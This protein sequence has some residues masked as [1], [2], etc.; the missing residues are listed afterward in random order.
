M[1][2]NRI[3][4]KI[5]DPITG[6]WIPIEVLGDGGR[7]A[8]YQWLE[9]HPEAT[10]SVLDG[11]ISTI[12]LADGSV[13]D[14]KLA[15]NSVTSS[16]IENGSVTN[17]K[18]TNSSVTTP[19]ISDNS[20][21][22]SK[23][24]D[25]AVTSTKLA[26]SSV[27]TPSILDSSVVSSKIADNSVTTAKIV[28]G[29][30]TSAKLLD[31]SVT[32]DKL[33]AASVT[34]AKVADSNITTAKIANSAINTAK[35]EDG[36]VT[37]AKIVDGNVTTAKIANNAVTESKLDPNIQLKLLKGYVTP[38]NY[39]AVGDGIADDT[40]AWQSAV[41]S[42]YNVVAGSKS[43]RCGKITITENIEIDCNMAEFTCTSDTLFS[44]KGSIIKSTASTNSYNA[45]ENFN[46]PDSTHTGVAFLRN[47]SRTISSS[48]NV[49]DGMMINS[50]SGTSYDKLP[51]TISNP[52]V[53]EISPITCTLINIGSVNHINNQTNTTVSI[54]YGYKCK[55]NNLI[56]SSS[57]CTIVSLSYCMECE[58]SDILGSFETSEYITTYVTSYA[59]LIINSSRTFVRNC[60]ITFDCGV[61][62]K[63]DGSYLSLN[64]TIEDCTFISIGCDA[65]DDRYNGIGT[66]IT[67]CDLHGCSLGA[68]SKITRC[69]IYQHRSSVELTDP[70][71]EACIKIV[72]NLV[73]GINNL[74]ISNVEFIVSDLST[75][76]GI[77][78]SNCRLG[79]KF[80]L[81]GN[82]FYRIDDL[83][84]K[85]IICN[86]VTSN[87]AILHISPSSAGAIAYWGGTT[88]LEN[89]IGGAYFYTASNFTFTNYYKFIVRNCTEDSTMGYYH[90]STVLTIPSMYIENSFVR[91]RG[92]FNYLRLDNV[93][94]FSNS[95]YMVAVSTSGTTL[96]ASNIDK[97][98]MDQITKFTNARISNMKYDTPY[99]FAYVVVDP[100]FGN[101]YG[102]IEAT[103]IVNYT[104]N[105]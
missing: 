35:L 67:R 76:T 84:I 17:E 21:T 89:V 5:R 103:G 37:T 82:R 23:L 39:G 105:A 79:I 2:L 47:T 8:I 33:G 7:D 94:K 57:K 91:L 27:T 48:I 59:I 93:R 100:T 63:T 54:E 88:I 53:D 19:K 45:Y 15:D 1:I 87:F 77:T 9:E 58:I 10:T 81:T 31:R 28:D 52:T 98:A 62:Y 24:A 51:V 3:R 13:T 11:S 86:K 70:I 66:E 69:K 92:N 68:S 85:N 80:E 95:T 72:P 40:A 64:N 104:Y 34:T 16:K 83:R 12:K 46:L 55:V 42:G 25:G 90:E 78:S 36:S 99:T 96:E 74:E 6:S 26:N 32:E 75:V 18:L 71:Y 43:Y 56:Q 38:E 30:V 20:I 101:R 50:Y 61:C 41:D 102:R 49:Y 29:N 73:E 65:V 14:I 44:C 22:N 4:L 60:N 97:I